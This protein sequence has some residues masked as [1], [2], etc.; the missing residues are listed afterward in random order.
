MNGDAISAL[1]LLATGWLAVFAAWRLAVYPTVVA[2]FRQRLF[3]LRRRMMIDWVESGMSFE[4]DDE[5]YRSLRNLI[6]GMLRS[7]EQITLTHVVVLSITWLRSDFAPREP[8]SL[9]FERGLQSIQDRELRRR[10]IQ[11]REIVS[12]DLARFVL[13]AS[14]LSIPVHPVYA[15]LAALRPNSDRTRQAFKRIVAES[16]GISAAASRMEQLGSTL[17]TEPAEYAEAV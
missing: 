13:L 4:K 15:L 1:F 6:N 17:P 10:M 12:L 8:E 14:P 3:S 9:R 2:D 11:Y 16:S 5:A 7:V